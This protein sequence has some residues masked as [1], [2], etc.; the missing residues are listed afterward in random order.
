MGLLSSPRRPSSPPSCPER[1]RRMDVYQGLS[2]I[3]PSHSPAQ[4]SQADLPF[5][6]EQ[7]DHHDR[8]N[9]Y[10]AL[11]LPSPRARSRVVPPFQIWDE[12]LSP[13]GVPTAPASAPAPVAPRFPPAQPHEDLVSQENRG[14]APPAPDSPPPE[15]YD[16]AFAR[17]VRRWRPAMTSPE[18]RVRRRVV[19][20][21]PVPVPYAFMLSEGNTAGDRQAAWALDRHCVECSVDY[22]GSFWGCPRCGGL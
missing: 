19:P 20:S 22:S 13:I 10:A 5:P 8:R 18:F 4:R 2:V 9:R 15:T 7:I 17:Y 16:E 3:A 11:A 14:S 6:T 21:A 12:S 1:M